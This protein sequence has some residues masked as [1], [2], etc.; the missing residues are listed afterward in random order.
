MSVASQFSEHI[1]NT[2]M[3]TV[4]L[5][6]AYLIL[7]KIIESHDS[8]LKLKYKK[9]YFYSASLLLIIGIGK[10]WLDGFET[11]F[12]FLGLIAAALTIT[13]KETLMNL[14][15]WLIIMWRNLFAEGD[16]VKVG[17]YKGYVKAMGLFYFTLTE[18]YLGH[19]KNLSGK[20][21]KIPNSLI[22]HYP[23]LNYTRTNNII[24]YKFIFLL[25]PSS[26]LPE[27]RSLIHSVLDD[28]ILSTYKKPSD[29]DKA[30][31]LSE[32]IVYFKPK[33]DDP[34]GIEVHVCYHVHPKDQQPIERLFWE[35]IL[36]ILYHHP[37]IKVAYAPSRTIEISPPTGGLTPSFSDSP[38]TKEDL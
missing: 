10:I 29:K 28:N 31:S 26:P 12:A 16:L 20:V 30:R 17:S 11:I 7:L 36:P 4:F 24:E 9:R 37:T 2:L 13:Q 8:D 25:H 33:F 21:Y 15:G 5:G 23:T 6:G 19:K 38:L 14:S 1:L 35:E 32:T 34:S 22:I 27:V 18:D 3:L